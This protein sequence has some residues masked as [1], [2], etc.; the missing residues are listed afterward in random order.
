MTICILSQIL[1]LYESLM[2][3]AI[4]IYLTKLVN[5]CSVKIETLVTNKTVSKIDFLSLQ[6]KKNTDTVQFVLIILPILLSLSLL[7][8]LLYT[9][10]FMI[11][12]I[13]LAH[14]HLTVKTLGEKNEKIG[15]GKLTNPKL[16]QSGKKLFYTK[17]QQKEN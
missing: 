10:V 4:I 5:M 13:F 12:I 16:P 2:I 17:Q 14:C 7:Y 9:V 6:Q 15:G 11:W 8:G 3:L 1:S